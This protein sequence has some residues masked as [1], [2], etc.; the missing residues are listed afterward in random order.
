VTCCPHDARCR[1]HEWAC[2]HCRTGL[3]GQVDVLEVLV[4]T[5]KH[6]ALPAYCL[7]GVPE[8]VRSYTRVAASQ[9][10]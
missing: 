4:R 10:L 9:H 5:A 8:P 2:R 7:A 1:A 3:A 6:V